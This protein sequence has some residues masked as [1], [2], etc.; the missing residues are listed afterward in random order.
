M[1]SFSSLLQKEFFVDVRLMCRLKTF[2]TDVKNGVLEAVYR[3]LLGFYG[4]CLFVNSTDLTF[5]LSH[6]TSI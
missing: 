6:L 4:R 3:S 1:L 5:H 2:L